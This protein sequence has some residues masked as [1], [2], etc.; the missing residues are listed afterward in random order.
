MRFLIFVWVALMGAASLMGCSDSGS[1]QT[2]NAASSTT[3][4]ATNLQDLTESDQ[5]APGDS[6]ASGPDATDDSIS[7]DAAASEDNEFPVP[8]EGFEL[9]LSESTGCPDLWMMVWNPED[10]IAFRFYREG[11]LLMSLDGSDDFFYYEETV[12]AT[13]GPVDV[14]LLVGEHVSRNFC[15]DEL[16]PDLNHQIYLPIA[17]MVRF[18]VYLKGD[19]IEDGAVGR[20]SLM[21]T[22]FQDDEG[23]IV[24]LFQGFENIQISEDAG[25]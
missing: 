14:Q 17:G 4:D 13:D 12:P 18:E 11:A 20:F 19:T 3:T 23:N 22:T 1:E 24:E 5:D 15:T 2:E 9:T 25:G 6:T 7:S 16:D 21:A 8:E 10:T